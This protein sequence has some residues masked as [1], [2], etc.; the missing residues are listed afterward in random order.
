MCNL[1]S[2]NMRIS[3]KVNSLIYGVSGHS[4]SWGNQKCDRC[5]GGGKQG[6]SDKHSKVKYTWIKSTW[7]QG[8]RD[9]RWDFTINNV[10][11]W[12]LL[13]T[14][15]EHRNLVLGISE[16]KWRWWRWLL[17]SGKGWKLISNCL[18]VLW[19][20]TSYQLTLFRV[21]L[22]KRVELS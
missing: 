6:A 21:S 8:W 16:V 9:K 5:E 22:V 1:Y 14:K 3:Y 20:I 11:G 2:L 18:W 10:Q 12:K 15:F 19:D 7:R 4:I 13:K 17:E